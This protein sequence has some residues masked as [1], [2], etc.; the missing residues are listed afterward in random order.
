MAHEHDITFGPFRLEM[1]HGGL[2]RGAQ[3]I[4]LRPRSR[5]MLRYVAQDEG[6]APRVLRGHFARGRN[7]FAHGDL[8][9]RA[10]LEQSLGFR[11]TTS[12]AISK[13]AG[14]CWRTPKARTFTLYSASLPIERLG[15][16]VQKHRP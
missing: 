5:A 10:H 4:A 12:L 2:W 9:A 15:N 8:A 1:P 7:A 11:D 13:I 16:P 6:D 3:S 14:Y